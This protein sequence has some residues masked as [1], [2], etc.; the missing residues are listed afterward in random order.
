MRR[1]QLSKL[2]LK[3]KNHP[4]VVFLVAIFFGWVEMLFIDRKGKINGKTNIVAK[5]FKGHD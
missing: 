3:L 5:I 1:C 4:W 2:K